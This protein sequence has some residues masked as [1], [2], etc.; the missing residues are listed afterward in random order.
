MIWTEEA[1]KAVGRVPFFA[2]GK[3]R[4]EVEKEASGQGSSRVLLRHVRDCREKFWSEKAFEPGGFQVETCF[5]SGGCENRA[6][7]S[8]AL[9]DELERLLVRRNIAGFLKERV[10]GPLKMHHEFRICVSECPNACSRPQIADVGIIGALRP[11]ASDESC[12]GCGACAS[13]CIETAIRV[14][15]GANAPAIDSDKCVT[16]GKCVSACPSGAMG[17]AEKGW[18]IMVGGRLGRHPQ[19]GRELEGIHS[20][21]EVLAI[22]ERCLD[23]YFAQNIAG[24]RFGTILNRVGYDLIENTED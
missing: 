16:C 19:L 4:R 24:E 6:I 14:E 5:G 17:E 9:V 18:R 3:V 12:T 21:E 1:E 23:I 20:K 22:V 15:P 11:G 2:R 13:S 8:E 7:E 10:I